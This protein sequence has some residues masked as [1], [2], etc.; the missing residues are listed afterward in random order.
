MRKVGYSVQLCLSVYVCI[1]IAIYVNAKLWI[2]ASSRVAV[3]SPGSVH[4]RGDSLG[5]PL[6]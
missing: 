6:T 2:I 4:S 1:Y 3:G 5:P